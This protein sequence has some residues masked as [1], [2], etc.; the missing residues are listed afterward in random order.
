MQ[1]AEEKKRKGRAQ[2]ILY[3]S[4]KYSSNTGKKQVN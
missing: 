3:L 4:N 2:F 1:K